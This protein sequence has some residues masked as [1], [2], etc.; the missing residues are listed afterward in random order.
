MTKSCVL[1]GGGSSLKDFN[2]DSLQDSY[3]D[4]VA[5]NRSIES[6]PFAEY[7]FTADRTFVTEHYDLIEKQRS[8]EFV[9]ANPYH[10]V[11]F[12]GFKTTLTRLPSYIPFSY[13]MD[14]VAFKDN[15]GYAALN[16]AVLRYDTVYL[17]GYD[18]KPG[19]FHSGY[20]HSI[21]EKN[22]YMYVDWAKSFNDNA[23]YFLRKANIINLNKESNITSFPYGEIGDLI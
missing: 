14:A 17:L 15:S 20:R 2:F 9:F 23:E 8:T 21:A 10:P 18:M 5:I 7:L 1:I 16:W 19:H 11:T 4:I 12:N 13:H 6:V 22:T 3:C